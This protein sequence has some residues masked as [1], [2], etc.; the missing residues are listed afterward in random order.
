MDS[1]GGWV[2]S[3]VDPLRFMAGV[4]GRASRPD[5]LGAGLVVEMTSNG[6][7]LTC[8]G[9]ACSY[10]GGW[11]VR[12]MQGDANWWHGGA[13]P[14]TSTLLVRTY[15]HFDW[16]A[17]VN[18]RSTRGA[19]AEHG[20]DEHGGPWNTGGRAARQREGAIPGSERG[21]TVLT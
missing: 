3:T 9:A 1:H 15:Q 14:G 6:S 16:V 20:L 5:I 19:F 12:P 17:L 21:S 2:S 11:M 8:G 4:D 7:G 13:L 10:A 18:A